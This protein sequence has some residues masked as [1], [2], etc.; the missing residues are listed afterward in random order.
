MAE[1]LFELVGPYYN[2]AAA[3]IKAVMEGWGHPW[4]VLHEST[5]VLVLDTLCP[6]EALTSR[7]GLT[8]R[9]LE[10]YHTGDLCS[11]LPSH[12]NLPPGTAKVEARRIGGA[13]GDTVGIKEVLGESMGN[14]IDLDNPDHRVVVLISERIHL[15]RLLHTADR[16]G[17]REREVKNRPFFSPVSLEPRY[18]RALVNLARVGEGDSLHDP[19]CGTGGILLEALSLGMKASGG[20]IDTN[21]VEGCRLNLKEFGLEC[22]LVQG[23]ACE[24]IPRGISRIVTDP[25]Y[26]RASTTA[27]EGLE[28]LYKRFFDRAEERL[29]SG[30]YLALVLPRKELMKYSD[31]RLVECHTTRVH[32]SLERHYV[33]YRKD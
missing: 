14:P 18:A 1:L 8:H 20:D 17:F 12:I 2:M 5:G 33:V 29:K 24:T 21:M 30:G 23:D 13:R 6:A 7:L 25:P 16:K 26:G 3:E 15:G 4:K 11:D 27:G 28:S 10:H 9:V 19:F 22:A 31:L 32:S